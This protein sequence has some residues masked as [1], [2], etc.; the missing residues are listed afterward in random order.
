MCGAE[1]QQNQRG[2]GSNKQRELTFEPLKF[3]SNTEEIL[4]KYQRRQYL[5]RKLSS[6]RDKRPSVTSYTLAGP[7]GANGISDKGFGLKQAALRSPPPSR[8]PPT[9]RQLCKLRGYP[10]QRRV[11]IQG[12]AAIN[13]PSL[14][15]EGA[16]A[17]RGELRHYATGYNRDTDTGLRREYPSVCGLLQRQHASSLRFTLTSMIGRTRQLGQDGKT[18]WRQEASTPQHHMKNWK[19]MLWVVASLLTLVEEVFSEEENKE[20]QSDLQRI[21]RQPSLYHAENMKQDN[22]LHTSWLKAFEEWSLMQGEEMQQ[23]RWRRSPRDQ[24]SHR[25]SRRN[26]KKTKSSRDCHLERKEMR[27]RDLGLGYDSD[28]II[29]FK[30]CVGSCHSSR[31]N[32]DLALKALMENRSISGNKISSHPCC[33]PTRYETVSFMDTQTTWQTIRWLSAANCSCVG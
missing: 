26:G 30:Y 1:H 5:L 33:R 29:L 10:A 18:W 21:L 17:P 4:W 7:Q 12:L 2:G 6:F 31:K 22:G 9:I 20:D 19:V 27:V 25:T 15:I 13:R 23:S 16:A 28:E 14:P 8:H 11:A 3:S 24:N 32:Y